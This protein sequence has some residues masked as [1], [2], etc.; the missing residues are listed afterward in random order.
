ILGFI[1]I[2]ALQK[3]AHDYGIT[4]WWD[5][6][7][8]GGVAIALAVLM[9]PRRG[10]LACTLFL[11]LVWGWWSTLG[12]MWMDPHRSPRDMMAVV[13]EQLGSQGELAMLDFS[14]E[15]LLHAH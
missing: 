5:W 12:Y 10:M 11:W 1:R 7:V 14:E 15:T 2:G 9:R 8:L 4:P 13:D 6:L 3:L